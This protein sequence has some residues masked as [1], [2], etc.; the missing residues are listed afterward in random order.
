MSQIRVELHNLG[1]IFFCKYISAEVNDLSRETWMKCF[2][3][4]LEVNVAGREV[5]LEPGV[6][7]P[8]C[9]AGTPAHE[10]LSIQQDLEATLPWN[11]FFFLG[12][13]CTMHME[14]CCH[15]PQY[16]APVKSYPI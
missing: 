8:H 3:F 1:A 10:D 14:G 5:H 15:L 12:A 16:I 4:Q 2:S 11:A 9:K 7:K 6:S 13:I